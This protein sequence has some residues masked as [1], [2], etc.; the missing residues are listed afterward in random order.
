[1][2]WTT[3]QQKII[4]FFGVKTYANSD[5]IEKIPKEK[6]RYKCHTCKNI[7]DSDELN[8]GK[9]PECGETHIIVMCPLDHCNCPHTI[10]A[11][12]REECPICG[13]AICPDCGTHDVIQISRVTGYLSEVSGW[14]EAKRQELKDRMHY[15]GVT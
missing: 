9:C 4:D 2:I 6:R 5:W 14:N 10:P 15:N 11:T 1:M 8:E 12:T 13:Q 3:E 7:W